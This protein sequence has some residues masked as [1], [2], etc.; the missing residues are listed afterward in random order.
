MLGV[1]VTDQHWHNT[2]RRHL[3]GAHRCEEEAVRPLVA[4]AVTRKPGSAS[5]SENCWAET[6]SVCAAETEERAEPGHRRLHGLVCSVHN[7]R[8]S[9][10]IL[11]PGM[12][13]VAARSRAEDETPG[14]DVV[15]EF[16][17]PGELGCSLQ[18]SRCRVQMLFPVTF[19]VLGSLEKFN[20]EE[21]GSGKNP[22]RIWLQL[23]GKRQAVHKAKEYI[24]G[25]CEPEMEIK[26]SY[27]KEMHCIFAGAQSLFL[28]HLITDT[29]AHVAML[30]IGHLGIK[31]GT[32]PVVMAQSHIQ[33][34]VRLFKN[35]E[36]LP[37][38]REP[39]VKKRFKCFVEANADKYTMDLLLLPS[40]LKEELLNLAS[41][42]QFCE[43]D[44]E[45]A[46]VI[47]NAKTHSSTCTET[48]GKKPRTPV[49]ELTSQLDSVFSSV[50]ET[51]AHS[52]LVSLT[53]QDRLSTKRRCSENEE[54]C[55]KKPFSLDCIQKDGCVSSASAANM[56]II[57][58]MADSSEDSLI[59][60]DD[61]NTVSPES[62]YKILVNF[63]TTMRYSKEVVEKVIR[64][65]GQSEEPLKLLEEI[66]KE[67]DKLPTAMTESRQN[68]KDGNASM[69]RQEVMEDPGRTHTASHEDLANIRKNN[70]TAT[71]R[72][73]T[74]GPG[75]ERSLPKNVTFVARGAS[76]PPRNIIVIPDGPGPSNVLPVPQV[77]K[78]IPVRCFDFTHPP[79]PVQS[80]VKPSASVRPEK[81]NPPVTG[82]QIFLNAIKTPYQ[83]ELKN[84]PGRADL[85][86]IIIDG[87]NVAISHGLQKFFSCRGI[88]IAVEYFWNKGHRNITV[89]V[90][91]WRT[92]RDPNI[93]EQQF[94][95]QLEELGIL[96]FTPSRTVLGSRI[97]SHDDRF[98]LHLAEKTGGI[99]VT[100]DNLREFVVESA[101]WTKIIKERLL[102]FTF[103][104]DIFMIPDDPLGRHGPKLDNF[105]SNQPER[106]AMLRHRP[107]K[108]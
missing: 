3:V 4:G 68:A 57:D 59:I 33:Q 6:L 36:S 54:R 56:P 25:L 99:I 71:Q 12:A 46:A 30:E 95:Q 29:S 107:K 84:E 65:L 61:D 75:M 74:Q 11:T 67:S 37:Q 8:H 21:A 27:P 103:A 10:L 26:E 50:P 105:L 41:E 86:H 106:R 17:A 28:D 91:Q 24:K 1:V 32:E 104:G 44:Q 69:L 102:Q 14:A 82:M 101:A 18:R 63:F 7:E 19:T 38:S 53:H 49:T 9:G 98:L 43:A 64:E 34:F 70:P 15:D 92:K 89:F 16:T 47:T 45:I 58:L 77:T 2:E 52:A 83:L 60:V 76:S 96:S 51:A 55:L 87:S 73:Q 97:C 40:A 66:K 39:E 23:K 31:G 88:A 94:L 20:Y 48:S 13:D 79:K 35:N 72:L 85:K 78:G 22:G 42:D 108:Y 5:S 100:N 81:H 90:P 93:T 80:D 62:E